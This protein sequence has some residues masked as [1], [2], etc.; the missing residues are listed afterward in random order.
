M[1]LPAGEQ[2]HRAPDIFGGSS[3]LA[4][5]HDGVCCDFRRGVRTVPSG[6]C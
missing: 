3:C 4:H 6:Y 1:F 2:K 5:C